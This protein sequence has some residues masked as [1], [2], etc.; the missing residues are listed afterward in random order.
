MFK[1]GDKVRKVKGYGFEGE[2]VAVF[3]N[4]QG[5][6]RVVA[7]HFDSRTPTAA[8]IAHIYNEAQLEVYE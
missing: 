2:I 1:L 7:E 3:K 8:G 6:I 4:S 5:Q